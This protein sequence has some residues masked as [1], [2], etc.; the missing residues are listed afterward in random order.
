MP[1]TAMRLA[2]VAAAMSNA[3]L[4][5]FLTSLSE[6]SDVTPEQRAALDEAV[7]RLKAH[8]IGESDQSRTHD[9]S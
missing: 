3:E 2:A 9:V 5:E 4:S 8:R 1:D 6:C 7:L